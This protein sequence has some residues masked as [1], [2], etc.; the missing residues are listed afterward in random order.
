MTDKNVL[1]EK[2]QKRQD[3]IDRIVEKHEVEDILA[4][5]DTGDPENMMRKFK[6]VHP[7]DGGFADLARHSDL[8]VEVIDLVNEKIEDATEKGEPIYSWDIYKSAGEEVRKSTLEYDAEN[9]YNLYRKTPLTAEDDL[10]LD[11]QAAIEQMQFD[12]NQGV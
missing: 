8:M 2:N 9:E 10:E 7:A 1:D 12:R 5:A 6:E 3:M 4:G 11:R